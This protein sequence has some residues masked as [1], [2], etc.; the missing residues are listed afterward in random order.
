MRST[1]LGQDHREEDSVLAEYVLNGF[2]EKAITILIGFEG[3][4]DLEA[5][6]CYID[7]GVMGYGFDIRFRTPTSCQ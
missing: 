3:S 4:E 1:G 2:K 6:F 7:S 5:E